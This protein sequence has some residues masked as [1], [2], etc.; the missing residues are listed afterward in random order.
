GRLI[1]DAFVARPGR[2]VMS[3]DYSQIEL[4]VLAHLSH[5]EQLVE[6]FSTGQDVHVRTARAIF[7]VGEGEVT[8]EQRAQSKTVN[9][10]VIYGQTQFALAR[11]LRIERS[12]AARYIRA[13][14][15]QYAGVRQYMEQ[16]V[17]T[18]RR[19]GVTRTLL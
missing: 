5:D 9:F 8:R 16:V 15:E 17:D 7:G 13:F 12:E 18:A 10:A 19:E 1:R 4:R 14:F 11:N 6:A 3:V 2:K